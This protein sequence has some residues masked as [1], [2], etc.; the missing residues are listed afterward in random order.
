MKLNVAGY[1]IITIFSL[2]VV[3]ARTTAQN[4]QIKPILQSIR[5]QYA[6][7]RRTAVFDVSYQRIKKG[8]IIRGEVDNLVAK[9]ALII[10]LRKNIKGEIFDSL[11]VLPD[12]TLGSTTSGI[13]ILDVG[14][15]RRKPG[16]QEE[17]VT[18]AIMGTVVKLLKKAHGYLYIQMPDQY[19][20]WIHASSVY[21]TDHTGV[22]AWNTSHRVIVT[23]FKGVVHSKPDRSSSPVCNVVAE[24]ILKSNGSKDDWT[25]VEL[26]NGRKGFILDSLVQDFDEWKKSRILTGENLEKT[27]K[28]FLGIPYL[29]GGTSV[30]GMDCSGFVQAVYRLNG[31]ELHRDANQQAEQGIKIEPGQDFQNLKKGDLLFFG[32]KATAKHLE[33]ITHVGMYLEKKLFIYSPCRLKHVRYGSLDS[34]SLYFE[35]S[36][37]MMFVRAQRIIQE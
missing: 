7:D 34:T 3:G 6:P 24:C 22:D 5:Q 30:K 2:L 13:V 20:G 26:A 21:I 35:H 36:L 23:K 14:N 31:R 29:W 18:Q 12:P 11:Q 19:L 16:E 33:R 25:L 1:R 32:Q 37:A 28:T 9:N 4:I 8:I 10:A 17:L 27:A 15:I